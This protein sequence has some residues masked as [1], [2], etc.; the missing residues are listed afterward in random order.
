MREP[1]GLPMR[2][3]GT[4]PWCLTRPSRRR[5]RAWWLASTEV[6]SLPCWFREHWEV[7]LLYCLGLGEQKI[8]LVG[9]SM[10]PALALFTRRAWFERRTLDKRGA[11]DGSGP[12]TLYHAWFERRT[13]VTLCVIACFA[14]SSWTSEPRSRPLGEAQTLRTPPTPARGNQ[15]IQ[16]LAPR[17]PGTTTKVFASGVQPQKFLVTRSF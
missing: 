7:E 17:N 9:H 10:G 12:R 3:L 4:V 16:G 14:P 1:V 13:L 8:T 5:E 15:K 11:L 2:P 6:Y